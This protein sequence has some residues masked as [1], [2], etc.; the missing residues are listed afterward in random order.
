MPGE[1]RYLNIGTDNVRNNPNL[2]NSIEGIVIL[3]RY[4]N[5]PA[6]HVNDHFTDML[7]IGFSAK[8]TLRTNTPTRRLCIT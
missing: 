6:R 2:L 4:V 5:T 1:D 7:T 3:R 8:R